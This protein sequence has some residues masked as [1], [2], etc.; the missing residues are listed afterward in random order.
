MQI[1]KTDVA[2][3]GAGG[4]GLHAA[5]EIVATPNLILHLSLKCSRCVAIPWHLKV[6]KG[7]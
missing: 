4:S 1:V 7:S 2:I 6:V 3:I 5:I